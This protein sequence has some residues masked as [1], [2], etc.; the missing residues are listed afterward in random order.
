MMDHFIN[1]NEELGLNASTKLR[2]V[3]KEVGDD[4]ELIITMDRSASDN[5]SLLFDMLKDNGFDVLPKGGNDDDKYH[6]IAHRKRK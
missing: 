4:D 3:L 1:F 6:I 5:S 2:D